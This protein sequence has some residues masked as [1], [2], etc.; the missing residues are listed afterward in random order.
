[1][2]PGDDRNPA[3]DRTEESVPFAWGEFQS[4]RGYVYDG[5]LGDGG[6]LDG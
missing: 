2:I 6:E 3:D 5:E 1:M 4:E